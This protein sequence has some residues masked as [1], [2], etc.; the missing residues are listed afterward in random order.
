MR[1]DE[2]ESETI[3]LASLA[4]FWDVSWIRRPIWEAFLLNSDL[5]D[6][7]GDRLVEDV[8]GSLSAWWRED[9]IAPIFFNVWESERNSAVRSRNVD[10]IVIGYQD[11]GKKKALMSFL[12]WWAPFPGERDATTETQKVTR[13]KLRVVYDFHLTWNNLLF[14][15][16]CKSPDKPISI[17]KAH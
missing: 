5:E 11:H 16:C 8:V 1:E 4:V 15:C 12:R 3:H 9:G 14:Y 2:S 17:I 6:P 10:P 13:E 7:G